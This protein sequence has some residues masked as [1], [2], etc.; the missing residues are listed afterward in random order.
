MKKVILFLSVIGVIFLMT[1]CL[2]GGS[3][4][5]TD[6]S[7][8]YVEMDDAGVP[9]GKTFS[10]YSPT[11]L[12]TNS[13]MI[14]MEPGSFKVMSFNWNEQNG[15]SSLLV[16]G[17]ANQA[18]NVQLLPPVVDIA[19]TSLIMTELPE[20]ENPEIAGFDEIA[21]PLY[22]DYS[23]FMGD[24]WVLEYAYTA[25]KD[26]KAN[27]AFYKRNE[28]NEKGEIVI[29]IRLTLTGASEGTAEIKGDAVA[30]NMSQLRAMGSGEKELKI[31]FKYYRNGSSD[32]EP[33]EVE[34]Q[35][36]YPW[37][38]ATEE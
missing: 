3:N 36:V 22:S 6:T 29:D 31:R 32:T 20:Q 7:F 30:L 13:A 12:I 27:V 25:K 8:V 34:S 16:G 2:K 4:S 26:Q 11:R 14:A 33:T 23:N 17:K 35:N 18:D 10:R 38:I 19:K 24:H 1:S 9:Y 28:K 37:R 21:S 15:V 5:Y